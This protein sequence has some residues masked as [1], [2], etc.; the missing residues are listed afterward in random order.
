MW[1]FQ[2][3]TDHIS[4]TARDRAKVL[5]MTTGIGSRIFSNDMQIIDFG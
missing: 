2:P 1:V 3:K 4:E 5:L